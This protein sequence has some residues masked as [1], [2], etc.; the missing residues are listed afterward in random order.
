MT[1][2]FSQDAAYITLP[3][4]HSS[5]ESHTLWTTLNYAEADVVTII[6]LAMFVET[7]L[8]QYLKKSIV[9]ILLS[10]YNFKTNDSYE[11]EIIQSIYFYHWSKSH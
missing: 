5:I 10:A 1:E 2:T 8:T 7:R 4:N 9:I 6:C 11:M 3:L